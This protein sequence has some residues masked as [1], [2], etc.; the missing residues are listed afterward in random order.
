MK[1]TPEEARRNVL[2]TI[3]TE[4]SAAAAGGAVTLDSIVDEVNQ[5]FAL[6]TIGS[7]V[8][9][10]Q[11]GTNSE[12]QPDETYFSIP[13][14][15]ILMANKIFE[16][17]TDKGIKSI[18]YDQ[19]WL[20]SPRQRRYKGV[21]FAPGKELGPDY[22]NTYNGFAFEPKPGGSWEKLRN[23]MFTN[24]CRENQKTF[25]YLMAWLAKLV[26]DPGGDRTGVVI[27]L[28]G[29]QGTGKG[30][31]VGAVGKL[32]GSHYKQLNNQQQI[33]GKFNRHLETTL[34][35]FADES[36]FAGDKQAIGTLKG[37]ITEPLIHVEP[38]GIDSYQARNYLHII[39]ASN[40]E[41]VVPAGHEERRFLVLDV[42]DAQ[43]QNQTYFG[44]IKDELKNGGYEAM[45]HELLHHKYANVNLRQAPATAGLF[46]QKVASLESVPSFW[47]NALCAG[48]ISVKD[49]DYVDA[50]EFPGTFI[51]AEKLYYAY[52][53]F[54]TVQKISYPLSQAQFSKKLKTLLPASCPT[55]R[56]SG[57][58]NLRGYHFGPLQSCRDH[59]AALLHAEK[60]DW[61]RWELSPEP[62]IKLAPLKVILPPDVEG[63]EPVER[64]KPVVGEKKPMAM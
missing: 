16:Y 40:N 64:Q 46:D 41:W 53:F 44:E 20:K 17:Y 7:K 56:F 34:L 49:G 37:L 26:Q 1:M 24:I 32:F 57:G 52:S 27:V 45:L 9:A 35:L 18:S 25:C 4:S 47:F 8:K 50:V 36:F 48:T 63:E 28:R 15:K 19:I 2:A 55:R 30:V 13:D 61:S 38:K 58:Q 42:A 22:Y 3:P 62:E 29:G 11:I 14:F 10:L 60:A 23:H 59:F 33:I 21:V 51:T 31:F 39:M 5:E 54:C 6:V 43:M 12:G